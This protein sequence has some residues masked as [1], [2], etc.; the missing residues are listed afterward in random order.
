MRLSDYYTD[1]ERR[2]LMAEAEIH[3]AGKK[4][5]DTIVSEYAGRTDVDVQALA[6]AKREAVVQD[7]TARL[8][9][10]LI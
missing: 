2:A 8:Q 1:Q 7:M 10:V 9:D 3:A 4:A 6:R 5:Y